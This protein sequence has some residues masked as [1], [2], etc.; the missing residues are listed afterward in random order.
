MADLPNEIQST[1][2]TAQRVTGNAPGE[3][4]STVQTGIQD[5][6][7]QAGER[8]R[9]TADAVERRFSP[10]QA[11]RFE[12]TS[13]ATDADERTL[14]GGFFGGDLTDASKLEDN[15]RDSI[16]GDEFDLNVGQSF[17][18][19]EGTGA[20]T[21]NDVRENALRIRGD[22]D[23]TVGVGETARFAQGG[24]NARLTQSVPE[25]LDQVTS[26]GADALGGGLGAVGEGVQDIATGAGRRVDRATTRGGRVLDSVGV[27]G[28]DGVVGAGRRA[29]R[30]ARR[31]DLAGVADAAAGQV[32][33]AF[34]RSEA[35][36]D[37]DT[38]LGQ[39]G[40]IPDAALG[41][42]DEAVARSGVVRDAAEA[43]DPGAEALSSGAGSVVSGGLR[44]GADAVRGADVGETLEQLGGGAVDVQSADETDGRFGDVVVDS[45]VSGNRLEQ[46]LRTA[47]AGVGLVAQ[48][49]TS[50][51]IEEGTPTR[52][53][54]LPALTAPARAEDRALGLAQDIGLQPTAVPGIERER[55]LTGRRD[56]AGP[57]ER[58]TE[59]GTR[60]GAQVID[61][62]SI[63]L[64]V[65]QAGDFAVTDSPR[66]SEFA[67]GAIS[68]EQTET[69]SQFRTDVQSAGAEAAE[70]LKESFNE[71]PAAT[72]G[73]LVGGAAGGAVLGVATGGGAAR[74]L[75]AGRTR[76][77]TT[78]GSRVPLDELTTPETA[79]RFSR[80]DSDG[81]EEQ[82]PS[83]S[84][85]DQFRQNPAES[86]RQDARSATPEQVAEDFDGDLADQ[87]AVLKKAIDA[88]PEGPGATPGRARAFRTQEGDFENPGGFAGPF[89][90]PNFLRVSETSSTRLRPGL[91]RPG[92][93]PTAT[94][95]R[96]RVREPDADTSDQLDQELLRA[97]ERGDPD[98]RVPTP[99]Q[100]NVEETEAI[101]PPGVTFEP[102]SS[103]ALRRIGAGAD[104]TVVN[105]RRVPI[106]TFEADTSSIRRA[107]VDGDGETEFGE[108]APRD[109]DTTARRQL[110]ES[111]LR[112]ISRGRD[113]DSGAVPVSLS[114]PSSPSGS[115]SALTEL[116]GRGEPTSPEPTSEPQIAPSSSPASEPP[117]S[118]PP[119]TEPPVTEPPITEPPVTEP[120]I[121]EPPVTEPRSVRR[122]CR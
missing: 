97:G 93:A 84:D 79:R 16:D 110:T 102:A 37:R 105:G 47:S 56:V 89:L 66:A 77:R 27:T 88:P 81:P 82:F 69:G 25:R 112:R 10:T 91:P 106:R 85:P 86:V 116:A 53:N 65:K 98:A 114:S 14:V 11:R 52:G 19:V 30:A 113:A 18:V 43:T 49:A 13:S 100:L 99:D 64:G 118:E 87:E 75:T 57:I 36:E 76:F 83:P 96:T 68:G 33:E 51:N 55:T 38:T 45:P 29:G 90:S 32:D 73:S 120:P 15:T 103:G 12:L 41:S 63:A 94:F 17:D 101:L 59:S 108:V 122:T 21:I 95:I 119:I 44:G 58:F 61:P 34:A 6:V 71:D 26:A 48:A 121:T 39:L 22:V 35:T 54:L 60:S 1:I 4:A 5:R 7:N 3:L 2:N 104:F 72:T 50:Q 24:G 23:A 62:F 78:G 92:N 117:I 107:D 109:T 28:R 67:A 74:A 40:A 20:L 111:D 31:G 80:G 42:T 9:E 115:R 46:D 8:V 70:N